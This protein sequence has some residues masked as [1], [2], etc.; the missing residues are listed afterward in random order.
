MVQKVVE[1]K[2]TKK[3]HARRVIRHELQQVNILNPGAYF[4]ELALIQDAPRT[5]TIRA[6]EQVH[7]AVLARDAF[8]EVLS[9]RAFSKFYCLIRKP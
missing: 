9:K 7:L 8:K 5:A 6:M 3:R 2:A 4:G 1:L